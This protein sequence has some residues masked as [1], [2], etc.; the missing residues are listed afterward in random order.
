M[1][2]WKQ[3]LF[4]S[5]PESIL[6][7]WANRLRLFRFF[8]AYGGH[9]N[10]G[11]SLD[12]A[13]RYQ[14]VDELR[15]FFSYLGINL[16]TYD[17]QP[18]QPKA[19]VSYRGEEFGRFP[20]LIPATEWIQQPGH[21]LIAGQRAFVWCERGTIKIS[22]GEQYRVTESHVQ[23]AEAIEQLLLAISLER[24]DPPVDNEHYICPKYYP[25]YFG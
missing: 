17:E 25:A 18:P 5:H 9:A 23:A 8:R 6:R 22:V 4:E 24:V 1:D 10:D 19:G 21:C 11:D 15:M 16:V 20:S 14:G 13:Y 3:Y 12:V 2:R 7:A